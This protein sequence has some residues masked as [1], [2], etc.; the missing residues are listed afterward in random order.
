MTY[1]A[2]SNPQLGWLE[3]TRLILPGLPHNDIV[4]GFNSLSDF[5]SRKLINGI[6]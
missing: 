1:V 4:G 6:N 2:L 3:L 5:F